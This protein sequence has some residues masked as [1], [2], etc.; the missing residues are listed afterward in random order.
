MASGHYERVLDTALDYARAFLAENEER[1][2]EA[3]AQRRRSWIPRT[4][5][6]EIARAMLRAATDLL[7]D[8]RN[9]DGAARECL[10]ASLGEL[11]AKLALSPAVA[12]LPSGVVNRPEIRAWIFALLDQVRELLRRRPPCFFDEFEPDPE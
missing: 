10:L 1:V 7:D 5:N 12:G 4:L 2:S 6:R 11:A 3:V 9:P 8:L